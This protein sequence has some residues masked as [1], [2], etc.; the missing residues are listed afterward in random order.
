[1]FSRLKVRQVLEAVGHL[2]TAW[3][4]LPA[5]WKVTI[6]G[7]AVSAFATVLGAIRQQPPQLLVIY[8]VAAFAAGG[9]AMFA[10]TLVQ[11]DMRERRDKA[12]RANRVWLTVGIS[13]LTQPWR[14]NTELMSYQLFD[15]QK[16]FVGKWLRTTGVISDVQIS[17]RDVLVTIRVDE[18]HLAF[19]ALLYFPASQAD[20]FTH[21]KKGEQISV[22]GELAGYGST[23]ISLTECELTPLSSDS[24]SSVQ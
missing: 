4:L 21:R 19:S 2:K 13:E 5:A 22:V 7:L 1:M 10:I 16:R 9:L 24:A 23:V 15:D 18:S 14:T 3:E 17:G 20:H 11:D 6:A 8:G 12:R